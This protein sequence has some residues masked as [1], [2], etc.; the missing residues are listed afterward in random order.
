MRKIFVS[1]CYD[2]LHA[3]HIQFFT[4][5]KALGD[6]L[7]VCFASDDV[8]WEHKHRRSSIPQ[9]HK[10]A[11]I[12]A[13]Q[14][15]DHV[16]IG[17]NR[18]LGFDF[19]DHFLQLQPDVLAV[20]EDD[21]YGEAKRAFCKQV[22]AQYVVLPKTPPI[23][24]PIS[25]SEIVRWIRAPRQAPLRVDFAGGWLD[26]PRYAREGGLVVNC[27]ISP[28]VS[29]A[30]W[31]YE[32]R[33]GVGGSGAWALL[34]GEDGVSSELNLGVGWQDPAIVI[35]T[36][37]CV[38]KSGQCPKLYFKRNGEMLQ[39]LMA[40]YFTEQEHD[41]P[42]IAGK[43]RDYELIYQAGRL[44]AEAVLH[45]NVQQLGEA[46]QMSYRA[47]LDEGMNPLLPHDTSLARKYCGGGWGGYAVYLFSTVADRDEFVASYSQAKAIEP[48]I[49]L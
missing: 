32:K 17:Q 6:H 37:L 20:T 18:E 4:E 49:R 13:L 43:G 15:V 30:E 12:Q 8:L 22:G 5:A 42:G 19:K 34:N 46:V 2:I 9:D 14:M 47:Q 26:V 16:V 1:G 41:T 36:G 35:E 7:T 24:Q 44:A 40:L 28:L 48:F 10:Y 45:E 39:G 29:L 38:W 27:A 3:G 25:T 31:N 21:Q 23:F 11:L 33:S